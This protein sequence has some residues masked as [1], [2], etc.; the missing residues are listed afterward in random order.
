MD[1]THVRLLAPVAGTS[2]V[3]RRVYTLAVLLLYVLLALRC[4]ANLLAAHPP[5][6]TAVVCGININSTAVLSRMTNYK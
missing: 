2:F 5:G 1:N 3:V 4:L 6:Y